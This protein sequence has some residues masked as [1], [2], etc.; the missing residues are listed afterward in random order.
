MPNFGY[1]YYSTDDLCERPLI[2]KSK[3]YAERVY[4]ICKNGVGKVAKTGQHS[5]EQHAPK[6]RADQESNRR[7]TPLKTQKKRHR[8]TSAATQKG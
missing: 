1:R 3:V 5:G 2:L 8:F 6:Q 4:T 7:D